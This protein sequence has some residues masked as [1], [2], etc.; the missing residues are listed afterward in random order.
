[1]MLCNV[2]KDLTTQAAE[3]IAL[4]HDGDPNFDLFEFLKSLTPADFQTITC[5]APKSASASN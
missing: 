4:K 1:M 5:P 2:A 3:A